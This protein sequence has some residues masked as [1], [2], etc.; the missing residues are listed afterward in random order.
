MDETLPYLMY[1]NII[2][3]IEYEYTDYTTVDGLQIDYS[4]SGS[5]ALQRQ[6]N[7]QI[8]DE[9]QAIVWD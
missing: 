1:R 5:L 4:V 2:L 3:D 8:P 6:I 7:T 9:D